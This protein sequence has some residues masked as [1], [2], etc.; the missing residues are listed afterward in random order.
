VL[1]ALALLGLAALWGRV[2][3]LALAATRTAGTPLVD[4]WWVDASSSHLPAGAVVGRSSMAAEPA[5]LD[6]DGDLDVVLAI[7]FGT[8]AVLRNEGGG[9]LVD[10]TPPDLRRGAHDSEDVAVADFDGD[11]HLD[12]I[13]VA[14]DDR[15]DEY[16][17][18]D[19]RGGFTTAPW[20][21]PTSGV[22]NAVLAL[23]L[24]GDGDLDLVV[25]NAGPN[26]V[27]VNDGTGRMALMSEAHLPG[28]APGRVTQDIA[29]GDLDGD[30]DLDLVEGNEDGNRILHGD[31][32]GRF[33]VPDDGAL[34]YPPRPTPEET[35]V[36]TL[37]DVDGDGDLDLLV[38][39]VAWSGIPS[40]NRLL[41]ND[42]AGR[43]ADAP[44]EALPIEPLNCLDLELA[45]LDADGDLDIAVAHA[46]AGAN[47][48]RVL[49]GD[50]TGGFVDA[51][52]DSLPRP[53]AGNGIDADAA[54][55]D[56][57][58]RLDLY[59]ANHGG[60]DLLLLSGLPAPTA[61]ATRTARATSDA[62]PTRPIAMPTRAATG[63]APPPTAKATPT[64]GRLWLPVARS[65]SLGR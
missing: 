3:P 29:A 4:A 19:G 39:N 26:E 45:D 27:L 12:L 20:P 56:G 21:L 31:G 9:R 53:L 48:W 7:E 22:S 23:D 28:A 41:L 62:T 11:G 64:G 65:G 46:F 40:G 43:F 32:T 10:A 44:A 55:L 63:E 14:E 1:A 52:T 35:R 33:D 25:G 17:L 5:D 30:G 49:L 6:G 8:N 58:G 34:R 16:Y 60:R 36:V 2:D 54:D 18:G 57:D 47:A 15:T 42:G 61:T 24:E 59:L 37:G 50:G 51:T 38:A 13:F